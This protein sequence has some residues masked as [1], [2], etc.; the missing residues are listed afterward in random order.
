MAVLHSWPLASDPAHLSRLDND[1]AALNTWAI[2]WVAHILPLAP[3]QL[4]EAPIF[5]PDAHTLAYSE[6]LLVPA[7]LGAPLLWLG[8]SPVLVHNL[9]I[10]AGLA[11]SGWAMCLL[12]MR[13]TGSVWAGVIAGMLYGFNAHVLTRFPHLQA[14]HVEF[15]PLLLYTLDRVLVSGRRKDVALLVAAFLLQALCSNY[16][17]VFMMFAVVTALAMRPSEWLGANRRRTLRQLLAAA[18]MIAVL[19]APLLWPYYL[20]SRD[21]G[22]SRPISEV[23]IYSAGWRDYLVTGGRLHYAWWSHVFYGTRTALFPGITAVALALV[24]VAFGAWRDSRARMVLAIGV[25]GVALSL[26]P[27]L[28]G[29]GLL[30]AAVPLLGGLR[31]AARWGWLGLA[32]IAILAGFGVAAIES[33]WHRVAAVNPRRI[34]WAGLAVTI[35]ALVTVEAIRTPVGFTRFYGIPAIY[36]RLAGE[37]DVVLAEFPFYSGRAFARN[38]QYMLNNTRSFARLVNGYSGFQSAHFE[39]IARHVEGFPSG[40][41][42]AELKALGVTHVMVHTTD[43]AKLFGSAAV[44]AIAA[45]PEL[46]SVIGDGDITLYRVR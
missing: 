25:M 35:A 20:V 1:D 30:H 29:Y 16:L 5:Y 32:A 10:I 18:A 17:L 41:A 9:L 7:L 39:D 14:Q 2:A 4:F 28:P 11:L 33:Y 24:A 44:T 23:G 45:A 3:L 21:Q 15:F 36:D 6:H 31:N 26:G 8:A 43:F 40:A 37:S 22:L 46:Q 34:K 38:G 42:L 12:M 27:A 19:L 13:W